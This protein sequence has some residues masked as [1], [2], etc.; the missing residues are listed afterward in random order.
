MNKI[1]RELERLGFSKISETQY[2]KQVSETWS[3]SVFFYK[4][5]KQSNSWNVSIIDG[6]NDFIKQNKLTANSQNEAIE[7]IKQNV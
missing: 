5:F 4:G 1:E 6:T 3:T 7:F 2:K